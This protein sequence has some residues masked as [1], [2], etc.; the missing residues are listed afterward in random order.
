MSSFWN[1]NESMKDTITYLIQQGSKLNITAFMKP[2]SYFHQDYEFSFSNAEYFDDNGKNSGQKS[3]TP[4]IIAVLFKMKEIITKMVEE[5][6]DINFAD[7]FGNL[8]KLSSEK[9]FV[10]EISGDWT[11]LSSFLVSFA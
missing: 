4:L 6:A 5:G 1:K 3:Y 8:T 2:I 7:N 11:C 9:S 10:A